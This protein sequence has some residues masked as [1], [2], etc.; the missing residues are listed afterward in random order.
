MDS[1]KQSPKIAGKTYM[2]KMEHEE[3]HLHILESYLRQG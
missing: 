1:E 3:E 2:N